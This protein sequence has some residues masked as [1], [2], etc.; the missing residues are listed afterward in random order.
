MP[1]PITKLA[2]GL[3]CR[4]AEL[5]LPKERYH[6]QTAAGSI[7]VCP[8]K[9]EICKRIGELDLSTDKSKQLLVAVI[10]DVPMVSKEP[11]KRCNLIFTLRE[12]QTHHLKRD[13]FDD[14]AMLHV[15]RVNLYRCQIDE[16]FCK[17]L[18]KLS[19]ASSFL[20]T[21]QQLPFAAFFAAFPKI[22]ELQLDLVHIPEDKISA[23]WIDDVCQYQS[24]TLASL[25][26]AGTPYQFGAISVKK[27]VKLLKKQKHK[28]ELCI[29]VESKATSYFYR[30]VKLMKTRLRTWTD[31]NEKPKKAFLVL[32]HHLDETFRN[33]V[34][35]TFY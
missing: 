13:F 20:I 30:L 9:V 5:A 10:D 8:P 3:R 2:Y 31:Y 25:A 29:V 21:G 15:Y 23:S 28:F 12:L 22:K 4:L 11:L 35:Y 24:P 34:K 32:H 26:V 18:S 33:D 1:Y 7:D 19:S 16:D 6:L 17:A 27:I 14:F